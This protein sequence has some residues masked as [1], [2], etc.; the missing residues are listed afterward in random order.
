MEKKYKDPLTRFRLALLLIVDGIL[1]P[2][3]ARTIIN[4]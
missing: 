4:P 1:C 3:Y 2:T